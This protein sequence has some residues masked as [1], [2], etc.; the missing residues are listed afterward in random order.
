MLNQKR[1]TPVGIV[2]LGVVKLRHTTVKPPLHGGT[3]FVS[4]LHDSLKLR[5]LETVMR[6]ECLP[7]GYSGTTMPTPAA[8]S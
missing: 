4:G 1:E 8:A 2:S 6:F 3:R 5:Q 7:Y